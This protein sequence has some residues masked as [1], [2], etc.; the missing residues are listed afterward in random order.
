MNTMNYFNKCD[1]FRVRQ[2]LELAFSKLSY[3]DDK[4]IKLRY[5][6]HYDLRTGFVNKEIKEVLADKIEFWK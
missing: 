1:N 6:Y 3:F 5:I 2:Q 4:Q